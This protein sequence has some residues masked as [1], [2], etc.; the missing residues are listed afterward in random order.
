MERK[1]LG[2]FGEALAG[3]ILAEKGYVILDGTRTRYGK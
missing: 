2:N 3:Q 1:E